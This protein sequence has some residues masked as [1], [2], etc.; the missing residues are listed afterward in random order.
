MNIVYSPSSLDGLEVLSC[1][2]N[3]SFA[4]HLHDGYVLWLNSESG[5]HFSLNGTSDIL[6]PGTIG[7]I[8]PGVIHAN[9]P[10]LPGKR[11][12]RSFYFSEKFFLNL[13]EEISGR[14]AAAPSLP[15]CVIKDHLLWREFIDLHNIL[16]G[17]KDNFDIESTTISAFSNLSRRCGSS[18]QLGKID[19]K[20]EP[21]I[22]TIVDFFHANIGRQF[23]L[24][25]LSS[26]VDCGSYHLIRLFREQ[27]GMPPQAYLSQLR[28]EHAR[29][30]LE[31]GESITNAA[32]SSGFSDQS[33][34]TRKFKRRFGVTPGLYL[35]QRQFR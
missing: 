1:S 20:K 27:K 18:E 32:L 24:K 30:M 10:C 3:Y 22:K 25:E 16:F 6:A 33:H 17:S 34:L 9:H 35:K 2:G 23:S 21:R 15:T 31:K 12:L 7:I 19:F 14:V 13:Y 11:H 26:L 5:E 28:L 8:E 4:N 29:L